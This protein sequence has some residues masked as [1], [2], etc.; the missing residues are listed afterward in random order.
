MSRQEV[1]EASGDQR[2]GDLG[3][4]VGRDIAGGTL[5]AQPDGDRHR[6]VVVGPGNMAPHV[7]HHHQDRADRQWVAAGKTDDGHEEEGPDEFRGQL[8]IQLSFRHFWLTKK[9]SFG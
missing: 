2:S 5:A 3:R 1:V 7:D 4:D 9:S 8:A 6:R